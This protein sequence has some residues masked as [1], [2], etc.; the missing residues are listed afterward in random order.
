[1][2]GFLQSFPFAGNDGGEGPGDTGF[3]LFLVLGVLEPESRVFLAPGEA[4]LAM[5]TPDLG[6]LPL[7]LLGVLGPEFLVFPA[8]GGPL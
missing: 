8:P 7:F 2:D 4:P 5:S 6:L 3:L 1:M